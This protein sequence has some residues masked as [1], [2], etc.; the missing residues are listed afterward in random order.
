MYEVTSIVDMTVGTFVGLTASP[1]VARLAKGI[2]YLGHLASIYTFSKENPRTA[3]S[4]FGVIAVSVSLLLMSGCSANGIFSADREDDD[5]VLYDDLFGDPFC[6][7]SQKSLCESYSEF[8]NCRFDKIFVLQPS[9]R[10]CIPEK[11][12]FVLKQ[13]KYRACSRK[14]ANEHVIVNPFN[15]TRRC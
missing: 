13:R 4:V 8:V 2:A 12:N 10:K 5:V 1:L 15:I 14:Y 9:F 6:L 11:E 7:E 3:G